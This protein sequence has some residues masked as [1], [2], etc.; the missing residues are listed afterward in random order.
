MRLF[1]LLLSI[2]S[3]LQATSYFVTQAGA[4][5]QNGLSLA[6]AWS[7]ATFNATS[8]PTGGD[9][10]F[11]SG[12]F[13]TTV[14]PPLSN[15]TGT[16]AGALTLDGTGSC[17]GCSVAIYA[18]TSLHPVIEFK[19][20]GNSFI[21]LNGGTFARLTNPATQTAANQN[22][23]GEGLIDFG[24]TTN[25][26]ITI[27]NTTYTGVVTDQSCN[28]MIREDYN[29]NFLVQNNNWQFTGGGS[30]TDGQPNHDVIYLN[31]TITT[32]REDETSPCDLDVLQ[33]SDMYNFT[34]QGNFLQ[35][36]AAGTNTGGH[37]DV[38]QTFESGAGGAVAPTNW[39][40]RYNW[41]ARGEDTCAGNMSW[42]EMEGFVGNPALQV[43]DNVF[44]GGP[45]AWGGGNGIGV[46]NSNC[47]STG[48]CGGT[49]AV[50]FFYNNTIWKHQGP[51]NPIRW[52]AGD[53]NDS[54]ATIN[55]RNNA[56]GNDNSDQIAVLDGIANLNNNFFYN[57]SNCS[58]TYTG[59][60]GNC[61]LTTGA[62][63]STTTNDFSLASGSALVSAGANL[64][65]PYNMGITKGASWPNP[66]LSVRA[67]S[68]NWD[69]GAF[70]S[71]NGCTISPTSMGPWTVNQVI[72][73]TFTLSS[74]AS[75]TWSSSGTFP[76]GLSFN[77]ASGVLSG[78]IGG[79]A[80]TFTPSISYSNG[81][82]AVTNNYTIT[83]NTAA[84][85]T[86]SSPLPGATQGQAYSTSLTVI[87][88]TGAS[89]CSVTSGSLTGSSLT[90]NSNCTITASAAGAPGAYSFTVTPTDANNVAGAG[91]PF[92][93]SVAPSSPVGGAAIGGSVVFGGSSVRR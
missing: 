81:G 9:T 39:I 76:T 10:V 92:S 79:S 50:Y 93:L 29:Y 75:G 51:I 40:I 2:L 65:S 15:G 85:I 4:G 77:T 18:S 14:G 67:A 6:N 17:G 27:Q 78:T 61:S 72:S 80:G 25:H 90:L 30:W 23:N 73:Q 45:C 87:N 86:T 58:S 83:V 36:N 91:S 26:D 32:N 11:F 82:S 66:A 71:G 46:H 43:Y 53:G 13:T 48:A 8:T 68:G 20:S 38:I 22:S 63:T 70:V 84:S 59:A 19:F 89:T 64:G 49:P 16:G 54:A 41:I 34:V 60:S 7:I 62:F 69:A 88:G 42:F 44:V 5:A 47:A 12:T 1:I 28:P 37:Q 55:A 24:K 21:T 74:C 35:N 3:P 56:A 33:P 52:G 31:N 57:Y